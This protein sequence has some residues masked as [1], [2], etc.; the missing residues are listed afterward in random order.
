MRHR[1]MHLEDAKIVIL[2]S[3]FERGGAE[4][5]AYLLARELKRRHRLDVEV[6]ALKLDGSYEK[7]FQ[8]LGVP[9][10]VLWFNSNPGFVSDGVA[11][12]RVP[13]HKLFLQD[14]LFLLRWLRRLRRVAREFKTSR[15]DVVLP[16]TTW[17]N[18][19]AGLTY[20]FGGVKLAI[21]GERSA[22]LERVPGLENIAVRQYRRFVANSTAGVEFLRREMAVP[23]EQLFMIP[24]GVEETEQK[25]LSDWRVRLGLGADQ[26]LVAKVANISRYKD[27][28]TLL[29]AWK[30]VQ[31]GWPAGE[32]PVLALAGH[33]SDRYDLCRQIVSE[34][35]LDDTVRFLGSITDVPALLHAADLT[36]FSSPAEGM[37]NGLLECMA[38]GKAVVASDLPGVRDA[39]GPDGGDMLV[40]PGDVDGF[41]RMLLALLQDKDRREALGRRNLARVRSELSVERMAES[42]IELIRGAW[43]DHDA[44]S[45]GAVEL[46]IRRGNA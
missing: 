35:G 2:I 16:L 18:V 20:R 7:D 12:K 29:R 46:S 32:R 17:P 40:V 27:H 22:G 36:V 21:W 31:D 34:A 26:L 19:I 39:L 25:P 4:R 8:A 23:A 42:Y 37:P 15:V 3:V 10:R 28:A 13:T 24:N 43:P 14:P 33:P 44:E 41:A 9:T 11:L 1:A 38:A 5:Q 30:L 6:W 45:A